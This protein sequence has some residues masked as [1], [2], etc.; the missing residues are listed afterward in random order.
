MEGKDVIRFGILVA[1][2]LLAGSVSTGVPGQTQT[3]IRAE[4][5][6]VNVVF[7]AFDRHN[8]EVPGLNAADFL[9]FEDRVPQKIQLFSSTSTGD[10][11]L[12]IA[13]CIDMSSSMQDKLEDE[14]KAAAD[15]FRSVIRREKDKA[16]LIQF[17]S[18]VEIVHDFTSN[19]EE[20]INAM[21]S[22]EAGGSTRLYDA[23]YL[24]ANEK[25]KNVPG[26]KV[27]VVLTDGEDTASDRGEGTVIETAQ[28]QD[29]LLYGIGIRSDYYKANFDVLKEFARETGGQFF[30]LRA[31]REEMEYAFRTIFSELQNQYSLAY[32]STNMRHNGAFR[33]IQVLCRKP[34]IRIRA[35][36]GYYAP[37]AQIQSSTD[38]AYKNF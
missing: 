6:L 5:A 37:T 23:L 4:V 26:R 22:L 12:A 18:A 20:L 35:R 29:V 36:N 24:A 2:I 14:K 16:L 38:F 9:V 11:P 7:S 34:G 1:A 21:Q 10:D 25:L 17:N 19:P 30:S 8:R 15:F 3:T 31:N 27:I 28:K 33:S 13:F 32:M